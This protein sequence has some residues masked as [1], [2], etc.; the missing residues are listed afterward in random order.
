MADLHA[1]SSL[2]TVLVVI[3]CID[4]AASLMP[5]ITCAVELDDG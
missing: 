3:M 4:M 1:P 2:S 5:S